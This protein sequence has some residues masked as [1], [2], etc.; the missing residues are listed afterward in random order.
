MKVK[1]SLKFL[2]G[3]L[4]MLTA[5]Q[6]SRQYMNQEADKNEADS[7]INIFYQN[8]AEKNYSAA[9]SYVHPSVWK[10][11]DSI[12][13]CDFFANLTSLSGGLKERKLD[14]WETAR[15]EGYYKNTTFK[16][17]Y[18]NRYDNLE[19]KVSM[20]LQT[21]MMDGRIKIIGFQASP[22]KFL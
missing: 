16:M 19:L 5:C 2:I 17:Y 1:L 11:N 21:D 13:L 18:V 22:E 14:H 4:L 15:V 9:Y 6:L 20:I 10:S 12:K 3:S 8:L 7:I